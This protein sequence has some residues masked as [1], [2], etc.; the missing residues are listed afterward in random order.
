MMGKLFLAGRAFVPLGE[1]TVEHDIEFTRLMT[2][3]GL[4]AAA[5]REGENPDTHGWRVL[6]ALLEARAL[7]PLLACLIIP[8]DAAPAPAPA[9]FAGWL[10][11]SLVRAGMANPLPKTGWTPELAAETERFLGQLDEPSDKEKV[12]GLAAELLLPFLKV[13]AVSW[14][15]FLRCLMTSTKVDPKTI[16]SDAPQGATSDAGAS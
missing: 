7:L 12:Y 5:Y 10:H 6:Q 3:A 11:R 9:G 15:S 1:S 8:A 13:D 14:G 16:P 4:D 2:K